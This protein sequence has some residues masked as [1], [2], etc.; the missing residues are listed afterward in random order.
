MQMLTRTD[1]PERWLISADR[2]ARCVSSAVAAAPGGSWGL[3]GRPVSEY[4]KLCHGD[5]RHEWGD[6]YRRALMLTILSSGFMGFRTGPQG[7][8]WVLK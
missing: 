5:G 8:E 6:R 3:L 2:R 1:T 7:P 4:G